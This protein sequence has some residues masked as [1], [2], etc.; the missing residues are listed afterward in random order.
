LS[1]PK[2]QL[3]FPS[4]HLPSIETFCYLLPLISPN[5]DFLFNFGRNQVQVSINLTSVFTS[6][7]HDFRHCSNHPILQ[8]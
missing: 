5:F 2:V 6:T 4:N 3:L 7:T 1:S 8:Q